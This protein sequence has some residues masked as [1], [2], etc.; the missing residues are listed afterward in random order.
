MG[1][2][3]FQPILALSQAIF[4]HRQP[5]A[6]FFQFGYELVVLLRRLFHP[7]LRGL[8]FGDRVF[9]HLQH[10]LLQTREGPL[11]FQCGIVGLLSGRDTNL[12]CG[13]GIWTATVSE[14]V[15]VHQYGLQ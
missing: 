14:E 12:N 6:C 1:G 2:L 9:V 7:L 5:Q 15:L 10:K 4:L 8:D 11:N 3:T 13:V